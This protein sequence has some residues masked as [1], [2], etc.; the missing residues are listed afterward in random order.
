MM[1]A[2]LDKFQPIS[3][4]EMSAV[5]LM[6]RVDTKYVTTHATL[7]RLLEA[8]VDDYRIQVIDGICNLPYYTRYFDTSAA[9]MYTEHLRG[10]K[11]REKI[12]IR[13][14][15]SSG[16]SFL[17]IKQKNSKGRTCK[18]RISCNAFTDETCAPFIDDNSIYRYAELNEKVENRFDR[19]TLVSKAM[20]ERVTI[21]T[22][23]RFHN[24]STDVCCAL[25]DVVVIELKRDGGKA[26]TLTH[27]LRNERVFPSSFSKY[28]MGMYLTD[29]S[30]RYNRFKP[31]L[32]ELRKRCGG[33]SNRAFLF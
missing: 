30:L 17:E 8:A 19:I 9:T 27:L 33:E 6:N 2:M 32:H 14:Y 26:S 11:R 22:H 7:C 1:D 20:N 3:L 10:R 23:L 28:C 16:I 24:L 21:D 25:N 12:R 15:E 4:A 13:R 31:Q 29:P 5:R 18:Q